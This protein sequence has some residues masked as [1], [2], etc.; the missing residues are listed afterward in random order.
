M[1]T[2]KSITFMEEHVYCIDRDIV[3]A[4]PI[5]Q[6]AHVFFHIVIIGRLRPLSIN[7][8]PTLANTRILTENDES[9]VEATGF[10]YM[11]KQ[12]AKVIEE[13]DPSFYKRLV[14]ADMI[15]LY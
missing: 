10:Q 2:G 15:P 5:Q 6:A 1:F 3:F 7:E 14:K 8:N 9:V 11:S 4:A 13:K 12:Y